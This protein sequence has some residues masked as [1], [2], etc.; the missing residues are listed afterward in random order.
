MKKISLLTKIVFHISNISLIT[1]YIFP[2][3]ILGWLIYSDLQKQPQ[4]APNFFL[5]VNHI[6]A[7]SFL[8]FL[9]IMTYNFKQNEKLFIYLFFIS[10]ILELSHVVIPNRDF[11]FK[12]LFG[13]IFGV[14]IILIL[15]ICYNFIKKIND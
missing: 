5:S 11:E 8:S 15:S 2:G 12:D 3:S 4:I 13:N 6:Y 10:I 14:L 1:L 9:G 7:F